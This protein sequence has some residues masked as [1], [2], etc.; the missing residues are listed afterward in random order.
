[1]KYEILESVNKFIFS[2]DFAILTIKKGRGLEDMKKK[3]L[4]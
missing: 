2:N 3:N 4:Y 1:M